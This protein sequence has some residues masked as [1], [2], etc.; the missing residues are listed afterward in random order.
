VATGA[1][2]RDLRL[3]Q[4]R[5]MDLSVALEHNAAGERTKPQIEYVTHEAGGLT[6]MMTTFG[7]TAKDFV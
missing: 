2:P 3:G 7:A 1:S 5:L 4:L 6:G